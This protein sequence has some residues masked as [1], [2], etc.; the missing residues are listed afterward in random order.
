MCVC[1]CVC[2]YMYVCVFVLFIILFHMYF[3]K[4][5]YKVNCELPENYSLIWFK[6]AS[7][8]I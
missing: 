6:V 7:L 5:L 2:V 3:I 1:V 4:W 8:F